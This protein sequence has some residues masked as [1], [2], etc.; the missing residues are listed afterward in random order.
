MDKIRIP[1]PAFRLPAIWL[2]LVLACLLILHSGP[3]GAAVDLT[4]IPVD[5]NPVR[6][7]DIAVDA[8]GNTHIVYYDS[9]DWTVKYMTNIGGVWTT[10]TIDW[11]GQ[12][13]GSWTDIAIT[14]AA[15]GS[16]LIAYADSLT[17]SLKLARIKD[18]VTTLTTLATGV[19][20][21]F[22]FDFQVGPDGSLALVFVS[23][24]ISIDPPTNEGSGGE[25][26]PCSDCD[27]EC[28]ECEFGPLDPELVPAKVEPEVDVHFWWAPSFQADQVGGSI[29][30]TQGS[31]TSAG[32]FG[33][34]ADA[35][36]IS[37]NGRP[38]RKPI[39]TFPTGSGGSAGPTIY[40]NDG[41]AI[42]VVTV[43]SGGTFSAGRQV[44]STGVFPTRFHSA[45]E[46]EQ[47]VVHQAVHT[48][49]GSLWHGRTENGSTAWTLVHGEGGLSSGKYVGLTAIQ[50][51]ATGAYHTHLIYQSHTDGSV[52]YAEVNHQSASEVSELGQSDPLRGEVKFVNPASGS[53]S[54]SATGVLLTY[55]PGTTDEERLSSQGG[56]SL[57]TVE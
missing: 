26:E 29:A 41:D 42:Q 53:N 12:L 24:R 5:G 47:G 28:E 25:E 14:V 56:I 44:I 51:P 55:P 50:E 35:E 13:P 4:T 9:T 17:G 38:I 54:T 20:L 39:I 1:K 22:G 34:S 8:D 43:D 48:S 21:E 36:Y 11:V 6:S 2:G 31:F 49:D 23:G 19:D 32:A 15:D 16:I 45:W 33:S 3:A 18:G 7:A 10:V 57:V 27:E 30:W 52:A 37:E 46:D 40:H